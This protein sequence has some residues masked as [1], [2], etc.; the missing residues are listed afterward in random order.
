MERQKLIDTGRPIPQNIPL[1]PAHEYIKPGPNYIA[2]PSGFF[3]GPGIDKATLTDFLPSRF[4]AD[5][6]ITQYFTSVH[7]VV[8]LVHQP[9]FE[10]QYEQF[11]NTVSVGLEPPPSTQAIV[12]ACMFSGVVSLEEAVIIRDFG[13]GKAGLIDNFKLGTEMALAKANFLRTTKVETLQSFIVYMVRL[14]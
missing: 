7:P 2:P 14:F 9:T 1:P 12:F 11:W 3:F 5:R 4:A 13:V 8:R 6:L 10:K